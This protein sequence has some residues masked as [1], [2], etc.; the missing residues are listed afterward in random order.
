MISLARRLDGNKLGVEG[1]K[2]VADM[3]AVNKTLTS[4]EYAAARRFPTVSTP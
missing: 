2:H 4:V 1:A 3:L